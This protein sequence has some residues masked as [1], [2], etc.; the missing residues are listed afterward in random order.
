MTALL[1]AR[2]AGAGRLNPDL[3]FAGKRNWR[4]VPTEIRTPE[5]SNV[6]ALFVVDGR[7]SGVTYEPDEPIGGAR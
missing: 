7:G 5:E 6:P 4:T 3:R 2:R 1:Q